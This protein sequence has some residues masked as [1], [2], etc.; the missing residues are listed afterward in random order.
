MNKVY[1]TAGI[2]CIAGVVILGLGIFLSRCFLNKKSM[3]NAENFKTYTATSEIKTLNIKEKSTNIQVLEG[4]VD[5]VTIDYYEPEN[6][7]YRITEENGTLTFE[8][9]SN[10][11][12]NFNFG[13]D[14][15]VKTVVTI[16]KK[17]KLAAD[18]GSKSG[19]IEIDRLSF[20]KL[21]VNATSGLVKIKDVKSD[22]EMTISNDSGSKKLAGVEA[23]SLTVKGTSGVLKA[24]NVTVTNGI[25]VEIT[26]GSTT[27]SNVA[28]S[29]L[30]IE[31]KSGA[32]KATNVA[33]GDVRIKATSGS[34]KLD[35]VSGS[36][37]DIHNKS[38][39]I[40]FDMLNASQ[41][42]NIENGSGS[43]R[44]TI[45]GAKEDFATLVNVGSGS[46]NL[47]NTRT[48]DKELTVNGGSGMINVTF[49]N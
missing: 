49:T 48:G 10:Y 20:A 26:S 16:P 47:D 39:K 1:L 5:Y 46:N 31:G 29:D 44:G 7:E 23:E 41:S 19:S 12:I 15:D 37:F 38:G 35:N 32:I 43:I 40:S 30:S 42:I 6:V 4:N 36:T 14:I 8:K 25:I 24:E 27:F 17:L 3:V 21:N 22:G 33:T 11:V 45:V 34:I 9:F 2:C 28:S 13:Y 18:I